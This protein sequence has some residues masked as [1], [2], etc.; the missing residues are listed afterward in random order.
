MMP[1]QTNHHDIP[2][3]VAGDPVAD[4]DTIVQSTAERLEAL[5]PISGRV[6]VTVT[7][8]AS[9][10]AAVAFPAGKFPVGATI[11]VTC[12]T[13]IAGNTSYFAYQS[14]ATN[15]GFTARVRH[16][17]GTVQSTTVDVDWIAV[18]QQP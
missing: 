6:T 9:G 11:R 12:S 4:I 13:V 7:A 18:L 1:G 2:Y 5:L 14:S 8:S 15:T 16:H 17:D 10:S 3:P